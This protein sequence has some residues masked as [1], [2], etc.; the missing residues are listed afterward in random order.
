I[1]RRVLLPAPF[2]PIIPTASPL[3]SS[4][5]TFFRAQKSSLLWWGFPLRRKA[6]FRLSVSRSRKVSCRYRAVAILYFLQ[7][8]SACTTTA[9]IISHPQRF[10]P[11]ALRKQ[12][13]PTA[14]A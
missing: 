1:L 5:E 13:L 7:S 11:C 2:L 6:D 12:F 4:K 9:F 8:P 14:T 3:S 10:F